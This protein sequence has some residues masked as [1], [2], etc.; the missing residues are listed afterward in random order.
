MTRTLL[1]LFALAILSFH[2]I[3]LNA[4]WQPNEAFYAETA[5][6]LLLK[7]NWL[8]LTYNGEPRLEK[9]PATY[10]A[11]ALSFKAFGVNELSARLVPFLSALGTALLL[12]L[13][14]WRL[15]NF[16]FGVISAVVFLSALQV[17]ALARY[18]SP[19]LPLTFTLSGA[20]V[21]LHLYDTTRFKYLWLFLSGLFLSPALLVKGIPF[22]FLYWGIWFFYKLAGF[23][24]EGNFTLGGFLKSQIPVWVV[25]ILASLPLLVW[26]WWTYQHYGELFLKTFYSEVI[27]RAINPSKDWEPLFYLGV[28]LWAFLPFSLHFYYSVLGLLIR[29]RREAAELLFPLSWFFVVLA[30]FTVAKGKIPVY[31]LPAFPAMALLTARLWDKRH[32]ALSFLNWFVLLLTLGVFLYTVYTFGFYKDATLWVVLVLSLAL[33]FSFER[34][35]LLRSAVSIIPFMFLFTHS[36]LP[37]VE[38]YRPYKTLFAEL[39]ALYPKGEYR[40]VCL[41]SFFK[42]FPF[43][44]GEVVPVVRTLGELKKFKTRKVLLFAPYKPE[45]WKVVKEVELYTGSES[46]FLVMLKDIKKH[47]RFKRFYFLVGF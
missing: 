4:I 29:F 12:I 34:A 26:Y 6:E 38:K 7:D 27:H 1:L 44:R 31:I 41:K 2:N 11:T 36:V 28:I 32:P 19:E 37:F 22:L 35:D 39:N 40:L 20:L 24:A 15:R 30:A 18:D 9:P 45:G 8:D 25:G 13:Y 5:R 42:N 47:K 10:W 33:W 21:F 17:F 3:G 43:Y 46:R 14:G 23:L 16:T